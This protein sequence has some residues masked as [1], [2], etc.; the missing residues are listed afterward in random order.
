MTSKASD[1]Q[2]ALQ[3]TVNDA[4]Q[5][6][7]RDTYIGSLTRGVTAALE[8]VGKGWFN[9]AESNAQTYGYSKLKKLLTAVR[10]MMEDA[11]RALA[12]TS[13]RS[14]AEYSEAVCDCAVTVRAISDVAVVY[15]Q[16]RAARG[17][18]PLATNLVVHAESKKIHFADDIAAL[19]EQMAALALRGLA[20]T[21]GLPQLE[22]L[23]MTKM[24]WAYKPKLLA[25]QA[26]EPEVVA[27]VER[28]RDAWT[29]AVAPLLEYQ[30]LFAAHEATLQRDNE[31]YVAAL[32]AK[33]AE[34]TLAEVQKELAAAEA[35]AVAAAR[36]IPGV[37]RY[38]RDCFCGDIVSDNVIPDLLLAHACC[39]WQDTLQSVC[40]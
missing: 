33:G 19:P 38:W 23:I 12:L 20:A 3:A 14:L 36:D 39:R 18:A 6:Y 31:A 17:A 40:L 22:P 8:R 1:K 13:L 29:R 4:T 9:L 35:A 30:K 21:D 24:Q 26:E 32:A 25:I 28:V 5:S 2:D 10:F 11:V 7:L 16:P 27:L 15:A 34:L 37:V